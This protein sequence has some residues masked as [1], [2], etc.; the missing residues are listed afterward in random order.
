MKNPSNF[1]SD[2]YIW[3]ILCCYLQSEQLFFFLPVREVMPR[4]HGFW[5]DKD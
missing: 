2:A 5:L 3:K 4:V 1:G